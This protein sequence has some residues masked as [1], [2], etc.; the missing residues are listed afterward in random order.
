MGSRTAISQTTGE[1][2]SRGITPSYSSEKPI[3]GATVA[4][5]GMKASQIAM[6]PGIA[7]N[8]YLVQI[9]V[10]NAAFPST[11]ARTAVYRAVPHTQWP[12]VLP[13]P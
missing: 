1:V 10:T 4:Y 8:V 13:S 5:I 6:L 7:R 11:V 12:A 3:L 2:K 9:L